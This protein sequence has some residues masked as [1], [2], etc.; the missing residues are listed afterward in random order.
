M[1]IMRGVVCTGQGQGRSFTQ[2]DW[3]RQ[4]FR[5]K[6]GFDPY[7]GTL[8][9]TIESMD[10]LAA[11]RTRQGVVIAP[12]SPE[13]CAAKCYRVKVNDRIAAVW[14]IPQVPGY[15]ANLVE[16]M[17]PVHLRGALGLKDGDRVQI[18]LVE[19]EK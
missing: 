6:L 3:V 17:A 15:P 14:I 13:Y 5:D 2:L 18:Q 9:L 12:P 4:Q 7:P 10:A 11:W 19:G 16:L 1:T 8:N